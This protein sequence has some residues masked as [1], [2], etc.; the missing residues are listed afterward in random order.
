MYEVGDYIVKSGNGVCKVKD[1]LYLNV[2]DEQR[3]YYLL[4]PMDDKKEEI[5]LPTDLAEK[6]VRRTMTKEEALQ[7]ID[8]IPTIKEEKIGN[9]KMCEKTYKEAIKRGRPED[10]VGIIKVIYTRKKKRTAQGKKST[11]VDERYFRLAEHSLYSELEFALK[12][13]RE[14][15]IKLIHLASDKVN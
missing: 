3:L 9:E 11:T 8:N 13:D 1:I 15:I 14:E 7:L 10:F 2:S 6:S 4:T 12:K 5:Y